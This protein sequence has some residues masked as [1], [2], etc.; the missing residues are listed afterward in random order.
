MDEKL[1]GLA[2]TRKPVSTE[3]EAGV[4]MQAAAKDDNRTS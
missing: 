1:Q 4:R 3:A 2:A